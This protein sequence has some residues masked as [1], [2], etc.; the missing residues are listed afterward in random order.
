MIHWTRTG[1]TQL[2]MGIDG[3]VMCVFEFASFYVVDH[4]IR[5]IGHMG[6]MYVGLIG[7]CVRLLIYA[8]LSNPWFVLPADILQGASSSR[9]KTSDHIGAHRNFS[10]GG[11]GV[12]WGGER[13]RAA[14]VRVSTRGCTTTDSGDLS[15]V[16]Q[17]F[18][19]LKSVKNYRFGQR[20]Y[21]RWV[22]GGG[23]KRGQHN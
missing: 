16:R 6:I 17:R 22:E 7:Y 21:A 9:E 1:G 2:L 5:L 20:A 12:G 4:V 14:M 23:G 8:S 19:T 13:G 10:I 3:V 18:L 11:G 15:I